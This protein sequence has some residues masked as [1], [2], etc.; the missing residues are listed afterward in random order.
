MCSDSAEMPPVTLTR[1]GNGVTVDAAQQLG[2]TAFRRWSADIRS[3]P[4]NAEEF[5]RT[6]T[7]SVEYVGLL[8][9]TIIGRRPIR[10]IIAY[11]GDRRVIAAPPTA[12]HAP[13]VWGCDP[14][15]V[16]AATDHIAV[17]PACS[18]AGKGT[19]ATCGGSGQL[20]CGSC[21]GAGKA[22]GYASNG[23]MRLMNCKTCRGKGS[24]V[25]GP[26]HRGVATCATCAGGQTVQQWI[27]VEQWQR[28]TGGVYPRVATAESWVFDMTDAE[29]ANDAEI[30]T[31]IDAKGAL[32]A[33][34]L[35][36]IPATWLRQLRTATADPQTTN[37]RITAERLRMTAIPRLRVEYA[38][39]GKSDGIDFIGRRLRPA[40]TGPSLFEKRAAAIRWTIVAAMLALA[41]GS[42]MYFARGAYFRGI[43][44]RTFVA[45]AA[46]AIGTTLFAAFRSVDRRKGSLAAT[47]AWT[48][49]VAIALWAEPSVADARRR[50]SRN[51]LA[52]ARD[53]LVALAPEQ[54]A[55]GDDRTAWADLRVALARTTPSWR[56]AIDD[57]N[58][59]P[60]SL[61]QHA[62]AAAAADAKIRDA[63]EH[64]VRQ[65]FL[66][67][68]AEAF[69]AGSPTLRIALADPAIK[70][71]YL[72]LAQ[73]ALTSADWKR[74]AEHLQDARAAGADNE[75]V[76]MV[77]APLWRRARGAAATAAASSDSRRRLARRA[78]AEALFV[79]WEKCVGVENTPELIALRTAMA[80]DIR[81][82]EGGR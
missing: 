9:T 21:N 26:C 59:V 29:I 17:C 41:V 71:V 34:R 45:A 69:K 6:V 27:E 19:C 15:Q 82:A 74:A 78:D 24:V 56:E 36:S 23:S 42:A 51:D 38:F 8:T 16:R 53:E 50:I 12:F 77:A 60:R 39:G 1:G 61:P 32:T 22:Y 81:K 46:L 57:A 7:A 70:M 68:A 58:A 48:A 30:I 47:A 35:G 20:R 75:S 73:R 54:Q 63:F 65:E 28:V 64:A 2:A 43:E 11:H 31:S 55:S 14:P 67:Q 10:R 80:S 76:R 3:A 62:A 49:A 25:C 13:D 37:E 18:G 66:D 40:V 52:G 5:I 79:A 44:G 4:A 72:P 33:E